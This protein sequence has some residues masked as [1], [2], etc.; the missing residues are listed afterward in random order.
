MPLPPFTIRPD[1]FDE[2]DLLYEP[3]LMPLPRVCPPGALHRRLIG[4]LGEYVRDQGTRPT[5]TAMAL[6]AVIDY[7]VLHREAQEPRGAEGGERQARCSARM[8]YEM[9]RHFDEYP[10]DEANTGSSLRGAIKGFF[11]NGVVRTTRSEREEFDEPDWILTLERARQSRHTILGRYARLRPSLLDVQTALVHVGI[12]YASARIHRGW[13]EGPAHGDGRIPFE[14]QSAS[15]GG[16][17]FALIGYTEQGFLVLNSAG[18]QWGGWSPGGDGAPGGG[19]GWPGV[20]L[21]SYADW[22]RNLMDAWVLHLGVPVEAE[23][24]RRMRAG[25]GTGQLTGF[26]GQGVT[27]LQINGHYLHVND[28]RLVRSGVYAHDPEGIL[29]TARVL[30]GRAYRDL[31]FFVESG[32]DPL[33]AMAQRCLGLVDGFLGM[34]D[35]GAESGRAYPISVIWRQEVLQ[36]TEDMLESRGRRIAQRTGGR[37]DAKAR[38]LETY[39]RTYM[40]P[41]W[42]AYEGEAERSFV[43]AEGPEGPRGEAWDAMRALLRAAGGG[44]TPMGVHFVVHGAGI[45]WFLQLVQRLAGEPEPPPVASVTLLAPIATPQQIEAMARLLWGSAAA[46]DRPGPAPLALYVRSAEADRTERLAGCEGSFLELARR[47]FPVA[48][49]VPA[50]GRFNALAGH[51]EGAAELARLLAG[52]GLLERI[53]FPAGEG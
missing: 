33:D 10:D 27:R 30:R 24:F 45:C 14:P 19:P 37:A 4:D 29:Q 32:L 46:G 9:A 5:C 22:S 38:M 31:V 21:L 39:A 25:G 42:R 28:G 44:D 13:T 7:L 36:V 3:P 11:H 48:G 1:P 51:E 15:L 47:C 50:P 26:T 12:V 8:L 18:P 23:Q 2:A 41:I 43:D 6:A 40:Q 17:A 20:A 34:P 49:S 52:T 16:H 35:P 53:E